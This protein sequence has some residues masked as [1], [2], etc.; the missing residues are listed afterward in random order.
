M[1][2]L[3]LALGLPAFG[4]IGSFTLSAPVLAAPGMD[5]SAEL[6]GL[7]AVANTRDPRF[8]SRSKDAA[9]FLLSRKM[10]AESERLDTRS[11]RLFLIPVGES[12]ATGVG[13]A[14]RLR[15]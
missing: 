8:H 7:M 5:L 4:L 6:S 13:V 10:S 2:R 11:P 15:F 1:R 9:E 14:L 3:L 12:E